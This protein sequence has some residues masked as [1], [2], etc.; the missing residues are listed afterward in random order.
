MWTC[1][2]YQLC[3]IKTSILGA[4]CLMTCAVFLLLALGDEFARYTRPRHGIMSSSPGVGLTALTFDTDNK[5]RSRHPLEQSNVTGGDFL[6]LI[7][8][9]NTGKGKHGAPADTS[10]SFRWALPD[11]KRS[12][13][14]G[15]EELNQRERKGNS[16]PGVKNGSLRAQRNTVSK[17]SQQKVANA[18]FLRQPKQTGSVAQVTE[19]RSSASFDELLSGIYWSDAVE[20]LIPKGVGQYEADQWIKKCGHLNIKH[21]EPAT[22]ERC[23]RQKNGFAT[24]GDGSKMCVRYRAPSNRFIQGEVLSYW[25][26]RYMELDNVP[27]VAISALNSSQ[28]QTHGEMMISHLNWSPD[29]YVGLSMWIEDIDNT[30]YKTSRV[31]MPEPILKALKTNVPVS[32]HNL[33]SFL[34][35]RANTDATEEQG[36][37]RP[38]SLSNKKMLDAVLALVQWGTMIL[39]DYLTGNYDRVSSMLDGADK[40]KNPEILQEPIRNLRRSKYGGAK[41]WMVDNE[42]GFLEAYDLMYG[43]LDNGRRFVKFHEQMLQTMCLFQKNVTSKLEELHKMTQPE[44]FLKNFAAG[45]DRLLLKIEEN[46]DVEAYIN[47]KKNLD[48][49]PIL[50]LLGGDAVQ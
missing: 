49:N 26:S 48:L 47:L 45:R 11:L 14:E 25:L 32:R 24:F 38:M 8:S 5:L 20:T 3:R 15:R 44:E 9:H 46:L 39:F 6:A 23:G 43:Q 27:P 36:R 10:S 17:E 41:L 31:F 34:Q 33:Q 42:S 2:I 50:K 37:V 35:R 1:R 16:R 12:S 18:T 13:S 4:L 40:D 28:W 30:H 19:F 7:R 22:E 21:L 29:E